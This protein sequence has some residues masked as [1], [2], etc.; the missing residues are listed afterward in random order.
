MFLKT[1]AALVVA[2]TALLPFTEKAQTQNSIQPPTKILPIGTEQEVI[3]YAITHITHIFAYVWVKNVGGSNTF[4]VSDTYYGAPTNKYNLD[5]EIIGGWLTN[6]LQKFADDANPLLDR[7][8]DIQLYFEAQRDNGTE[9]CIFFNTPWYV[10]LKLARN[11]TNYSV[12][13][14]TWLSMSTNKVMTFFLPGLR[15]AR[16]VIG[17]SGSSTPFEV[18]DRRI[19]V[20]S[21]PMNSEGA[22]TLPTE[23]IMHSSSSGSYWLSLDL[24]DSSFKM[25][26][27][28]GFLLNEPLAKLF[29]KR[30]GNATSVGLYGGPSGRGYFIQQS[31]DLKTWSNCSAAQFVSATNE[32]LPLQY[33]IGT[34]NNKAFYR[35]IT[36]NAV[37]Y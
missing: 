6:Q 20:T 26:D 18:D 37:P 29:I 11:G 1:L 24:L 2:I 16:S 23:V 36:T 25:V 33:L 17:Y 13:D 14:L 30:S 8:G 27:G 4:Y 32:S 21:D 3:N 19:N 15:W 34:T 5:Q 31:T 22:L 10:Y 9:Y 7:D 35:S 28:N 12:P